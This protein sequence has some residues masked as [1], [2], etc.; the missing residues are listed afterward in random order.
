MMEAPHEDSLGPLSTA[1]IPRSLAASFQEYDLECLDPG[2]HRELVTERVL[3]YGNRDEL[4]WLFG[5]YG[6]S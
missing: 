2:Q 6:H 5:L 3:A 4:R 1:G